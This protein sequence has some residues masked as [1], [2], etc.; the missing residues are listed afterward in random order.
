MAM[1]WWILTYL[2]N[3]RP[4]HLLHVLAQTNLQ[5]HLFMKW[6][7]IKPARRP[8]Y[9]RVR[10]VNIWCGYQYIWD[11]PHLVEQTQP[12]NT[13]THLFGSI[14]LA[15]TDH[16]WYYLFS[17]GEAPYKEC[18]GPLV[19]V[20]PPLLQTWTSQAYIG[21][22]LKGVYYTE[23]FTG[24][25]GP[26]PTWVPQ[27]AGL[28]SLR[29][30]QLEPDPLDLRFHIYALA[31][32]S[33]NRTL[34]YRI[35]R[36]SPKWI[37]LLTNT[38][39]VALT[40]AA[41]GEMCWVATNH[42]EIQH[43]YVLFNSAIGDVGV[44]CIKSIDLGLTWTAFQITPGPL[45]LSAGNISVGVAQ[46]TSPHPPGSVLYTRINWGLWWSHLTYLSTDWGDTWTLKSNISMQMTRLRCQVDPT[47]HSI[48]YVGSLV[49]LGN[50]QE[51][52][53]SEAHGAAMIEVD[54]LHHLGLY[55]EPEISSMWIHETDHNW[56]TT[57]S[58]RHL[59]TT[60]DYAVNWTDHGET[61]YRV[62]RLR[63]LSA[64]PEHL[65]LARDQNAWP[66]VHPH[67]PHVLYVSQDY[68]TTMYGKAGANAHL[69]TGG[70]D[71]IPYN[72]G[73]VCLQGMQLFPP[74]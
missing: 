6:S 73:G 36:I 63:I 74:Y 21:T 44:W 41:S 42:T 50:P 43:L 16:V 69:P 34:Y 19:H 49:N 58:N 11:T 26:D 29:I 23:N 27:N 53:R 65:Y 13:F 70:G 25:E 38:D 64:Q 52:F 14:P 35:P 37:P 51:L 20:P 40:G 4:P 32:A 18:Q 7:T 46:G 31:G 66:I 17:I 60:L 57:L 30:W 2:D 55:L 39:C 48:V 47:D 56:L 5:A 8:V 15:A 24:P 1:V 33:G 54:G 3:Y 12:G 10:G 62:E 68:G 72:C 59:W 9:K 45:N 67:G 28:H 61:S 22:K 71:S